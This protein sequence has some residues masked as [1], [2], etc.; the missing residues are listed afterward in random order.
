MH[1]NQIDLVKS[2]PTSIWFRNFASIQPRMSPLKFAKRQLETQTARV[3]G[4]IQVIP[5]LVEL[6]LQ[7]PR[8][9]GKFLEASACLAAGSLR[10]RMKRLVECYYIVVMIRFRTFQ[11]IFANSAYTFTRFSAFI[12]ASRAKSC[13]NTHVF[14]INFH[15]LPTTCHQ[16]IIFN[17]TI[18]V[19]K[20][21]MLMLMF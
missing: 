13:A 7:C 11:E 20:I 17:R 15:E 1:V 16:D 9:R 3:P 21:R 4:Q 5:F 12:E 6:A 10:S 2:F 19:P 8:L 18:C 14:F